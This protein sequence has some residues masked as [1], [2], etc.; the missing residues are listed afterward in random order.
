MTGKR[1]AA[2]KNIERTFMKENIEQVVARY[3]PHDKEL[4]DEVR[5]ANGFV[6]DGSVGVPMPDKERTKFLNAAFGR[7]GW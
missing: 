3:F 6:G 2:K 4:Q 1:S 5:N 7:K